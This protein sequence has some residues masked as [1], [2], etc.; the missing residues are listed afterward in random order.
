NRNPK[1]SNILFYVAAFSEDGR[2]MASFG[3]EWIC[4]WDVESGK[5]R[6][7]I[8]YPHPGGCFLTLS[9][10]GNTVATVDVLRPG[11]LSEDKIRLYDTET[12]DP[13]LTLDPGE[14]RASVLAFSPDD[15]KI[16]GGFHR[17][18][19]I[20]WDVSRGKPAAKAK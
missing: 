13:V 11:E 12:G 19:A 20:V 5:L 9:C 8:R 10:D 3:K 15:T 1:N 17:G 4:V 16:F 18:T 6:R 14:D 7:R 2:T